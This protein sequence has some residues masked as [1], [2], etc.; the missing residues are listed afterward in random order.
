MIHATSKDKVRGKYKVLNPNR[1]AIRMVASRLDS[2]AVEIEKMAE[3]LEDMV[4][5]LR[6]ENRYW[7]AISILE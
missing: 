4:W 1:I 7:E 5:D 2:I 3:M 6:Y